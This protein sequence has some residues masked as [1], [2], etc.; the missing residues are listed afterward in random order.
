MLASVAKKKKKEEEQWKNTNLKIS[1]VSGAILRS[2][3][4]ND[5]KV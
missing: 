3:F 5:F 4:V 1:N 2:N